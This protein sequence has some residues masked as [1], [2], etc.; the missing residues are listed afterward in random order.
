MKGRRLLIPDNEHAAWLS[1]SVV[2][3]RIACLLLPTCYTFQG[4]CHLVP[5]FRGHN[6]LPSTHIGE[7]HRPGASIRS[8]RRSRCVAWRMC[9]FSDMTCI[10]GSTSPTPWI[11][12]QTTPP[13]RIQIYPSEASVWLSHTSLSAARKYAGCALLF[14][15]TCMDK[16]PFRVFMNSDRDHVTKSRAS[17]SAERARSARLPCTVPSAET[18]YAVRIGLG[19]AMELTFHPKPAAPNR[20]DIATPATSGDK[21]PAYTQHAQRCRRS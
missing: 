21:W 5:G 17:R 4:F 14:S 2:G 16:I 20:V 10:P 11:L 6:G 8:F 19:P 7:M 13:A 18:E 15:L 12:Q 9:A 3:R 1:F